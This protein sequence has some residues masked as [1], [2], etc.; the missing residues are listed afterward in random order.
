M[1]ELVIYLDVDGSDQSTEELVCR[2]KEIPQVASAD[3]RVEE[4]SVRS[5]PS[6]SGP[7]KVS[8]LM[9]LSASSYF[10]MAAALSSRRVT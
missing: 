6:A 10:P 8:A 4:L 9:S 2:I 5:T 3:A 1:S 7:S